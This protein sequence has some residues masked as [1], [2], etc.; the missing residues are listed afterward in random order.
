VCLIDPSGGLSEDTGYLHGRPGSATR[1]G[2][3]LLIEFGGDIGQG[4]EAL[5]V[6]IA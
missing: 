6:W 2:D 1:S 3:T 5:P 4:E